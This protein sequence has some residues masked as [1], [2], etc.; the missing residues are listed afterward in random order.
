[1]AH[2]ISLLACRTFFHLL[3]HTE[4]FRLAM[5]RKG[6]VTQRTYIPLACQI[7]PLYDQFKRQC[8]FTAQTDTQR[9]C[10]TK[11]ICPAAHPMYTL[12]SVLR[13]RNFL[14]RGRIRI[15]LLQQFPIILFNKKGSGFRSGSGPDKKFRIHDTALYA[16]YL[17]SSLGQY[18]QKVYLL[19]HP[20]SKEFVTH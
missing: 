11:D 1:V 10:Y 20:I 5:L 18:R 13:I 7:S 9:I 4:F 2:R 15:R 19:L 17:K 16:C 3:L 8:V 14:P 12:K 6:F